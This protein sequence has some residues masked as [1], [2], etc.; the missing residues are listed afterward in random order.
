MTPKSI[1]GVPT[2]TIAKAVMR[3]ER[4]HGEC[5][6]R[7]LVDAARPERS[8][9]HSLF[10]WDDT[11]AADRWR[12]HQARQVINS[13]RVVVD[14]Q[15]EPIPAFVH[16]RR[17]TPDGTREGYMSTARALAGPTREGVV[18]DALAQLNGLRRRYQQLSELALLWAALDELQVDG[19][20]RIAA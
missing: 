20:T 12:A 2:E 8:P 11:E 14:G 16:V 10:E 3:L 18:R 13:I 4:K 5:S 15:A 1:Q 19:E 7:M 17:V 6:P 9:L